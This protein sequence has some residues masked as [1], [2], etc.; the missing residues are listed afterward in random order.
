MEQRAN[1][2]W[3]EMLADYEAPAMDPAVEEALL[4]FMVRKKRAAPDQWY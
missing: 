1:R 4:D 3:K 2:R